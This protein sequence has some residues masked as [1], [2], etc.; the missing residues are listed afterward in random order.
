[1]NETNILLQADTE[2]VANVSHMTCISGEHPTE[3]LFLN[4]INKR[5]HT[6]PSFFEC[7]FDHSLLRLLRGI[8]SC[9][10]I[11]RRCHIYHRAAEAWLFLPSSSCKIR[12]CFPICLSYTRRPSAHCTIHSFTTLLLL[13]RIV[14]SLQYLVCLLFSSLIQWHLFLLLS[15]LLLWVVVTNQ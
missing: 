9:P 15:I 10:G 4:C 1:M 3:H 14:S 8:F 11:W 6:L 5:N 2:H 7:V 13:L 12:S